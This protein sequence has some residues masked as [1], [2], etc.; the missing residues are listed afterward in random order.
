MNSRN[1]AISVFLDLNNIEGNCLSQYLFFQNAKKL[2]TVDLQ[3]MMGFSITY[4]DYSNSPI[5][6]VAPGECR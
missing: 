3:L 2:T 4:G 6:Q 5:V 1:N